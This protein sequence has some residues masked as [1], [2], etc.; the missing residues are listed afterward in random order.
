M[1]NFIFLMGM[2]GC[3]KS[4]FG[5]KLALKINYR[6]LDLDEYIEN[7]SQTSINELFSEK[8]EHY[9][10][11]LESQY[12]NEIVAKNEKLV[13][14]LGG[15]TPCFNDNLICIKNKGTSIFLEAPLK[16][17]A[18]RIINALSVRPMF[19]NLDYDQS[20]KKLEEL[21]KT[22][23]IFYNQANITVNVVD[24]KL[25]DLIQSINKLNSDH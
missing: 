7:M 22:R 15:G 3:G 2:P 23:Y 4:T 9:F 10:R 13:I 12:L 24:L 11:N 17:L 16:L 8:G 25:S 19:K 21:K 14:S 20:I 5:K 18:D 1:N 6:F